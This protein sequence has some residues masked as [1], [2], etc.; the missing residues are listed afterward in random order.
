MNKNVYIIS[1]TSI[2]MNNLLLM[3]ATILSLSL[4]VAAPVSASNWQL[5][6]VPE[7]VEITSQEGFDNSFTSFNPSF[8]AIEQG[9]TISLTRSLEKLIEQQK[10]FDNC[11]QYLCGQKDIA[12]VMEKVRQAYLICSVT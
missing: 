3:L 11:K 9:L 4:G 10:V 5:M 12:G 7:S 1:V 8:L 2:Q 6:L